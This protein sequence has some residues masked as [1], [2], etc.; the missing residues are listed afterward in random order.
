MPKFTKADRKLFQ[1]IRDF[2]KAK[3]ADPSDNDVEM[4][5][6]ISKAGDDGFWVEARVYVRR[7]DVTGR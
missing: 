5:P 2:A 6:M 3:Y 7:D 1:K 4:G